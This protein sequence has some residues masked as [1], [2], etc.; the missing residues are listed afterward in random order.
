M[1]SC[2]KGYDVHKAILLICFLLGM[3]H[4]FESTRIL[5]LLEKP[6]SEYYTVADHQE[7]SPMAVQDDT[8]PTMRAASERV[9]VEYTAAENKKT[10][11]AVPDDD[12]TLS[13]SNNITAYNADEYQKFLDETLKVLPNV[14][15]TCHS[16]IFFSGLNNQ[17]HRF[18]GVCFAATSGNSGQIIE[19]SITWKDALATNDMVPHHK[20][21]DIVHW[22][23]FFPI[24]PRFASYDKDHHPDIDLIQTTVTIE[25]KAHPKLKVKYNAP[26]DIWTNRS[27]TRP[28]PLIQ[29]PQEGQ[30]L[31]K[32]LT[33][34]INFGRVHRKEER[35]QHLIMYEEMLK[36]A[37]RPHPFLQGII[38]K[39]RMQLRAGGKYMTLHARVEPDMAKQD[40][41]CSVSHHSSP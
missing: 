39:A 7:R 38:E 41:I 11:I 36:G 23:S 1:R 21:W 4:I 17:I 26:W 6:P 33:R 18:I 25:G 34:A 37:L 2:I 10:I 15:T 19:E 16:K 31:Y 22:N 30:N 13:A 3:K 20:L 27:N 14:N 40:R 28:Q 32:H 5:S 9:P 29:Y 35:K 8:K 24:L 12:T